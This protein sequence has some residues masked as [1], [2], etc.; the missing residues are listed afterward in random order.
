VVVSDSSVAQVFPY[1]VMTTPAMLTKTE[2]KF[3][4]FIESSPSN[5]PIRRVKS[6]EVENIIVVLATL[7]LARAA[8]IKYCK[9]KQKKKNQIPQILMFQIIKK[10]AF[11]T[12]KWS[13]L[14]VTVKIIVGCW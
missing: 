11:G 10:L 12:P 7:V 2:T 14:N 5:A 4:T 3:I 9:K 6:P 1:A 8:F 13:L